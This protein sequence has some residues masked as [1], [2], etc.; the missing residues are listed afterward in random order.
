MKKGKIVEWI[1]S[2]TSEGC[3]AGNQGEFSQKEAK[4][5]RDPEEFCASKAPQ[6]SAIKP[7]KLRTNKE[8]ER[9][10]WAITIV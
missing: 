9:L 4:V 3:P 1:K 2:K 5:K 8:V 6:K 10:R 7:I